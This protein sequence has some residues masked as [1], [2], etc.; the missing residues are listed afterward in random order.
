MKG[1]TPRQLI[2]ALLED[3]SL[4]LDAP[5]E[6][7]QVGKET[8]LYAF[9]HPGVRLTSRHPVRLVKKTPRMPMKKRR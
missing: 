1:T 7:Q 9:K 2:Q 4:D 6:A 8:V 5:M 3:L